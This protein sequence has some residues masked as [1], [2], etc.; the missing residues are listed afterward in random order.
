VTGDPRTVGDQGRLG[1]GKPGIT[2]ANV[3]SFTPISAKLSE[4]G[5]SIIVHRRNIGYKK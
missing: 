3:T 1:G 4:R 5:V 2:T